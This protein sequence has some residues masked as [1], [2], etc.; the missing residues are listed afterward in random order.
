[1]LVDTLSLKRLQQ[2][3]PAIR[4]DAIQAYN[5]AVKATPANVH[6]VI[7]QTLRTFEE[8]DLLYQKGRTRPG[9]KV[10]NSKPGTSYHQYGLALDFALQVNGKLVWKVTN[11]WMTVVN[12]F[13]KHGFTWGGDWKSFKDYPHLEKNFGHH[14]SQLLTLYKAGKKDCNGYVELS[15]SIA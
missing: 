3:H 8:Q 10:T 5:E 6:P 15:N 14:W 4:E 12:I 11:D 1:M 13:K 2:L 9:E 7:I